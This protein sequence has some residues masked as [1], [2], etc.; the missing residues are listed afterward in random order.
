M[1]AVR[2]ALATCSAHAQGWRSDLELARLAG[3]EFVV[4]DRPGVDWSRFDTVVI[5]STWDY[6]HQLPQFLEW[7]ESVGDSRLLNSPATVRFAA[8]K[9]YLAG[10]RVPT[11]PTTFLEPGRRLPAYSGEVVIKPNIS[12]GARDTGRFTESMAAEAAALVDSIHAT[13]RSV[14]LQPYLSAVDAVGETAVV[15]FAGE[16]SHVLRK[17]PVLRDPGVAPLSKLAH[18]PAAVMLERDLVSA[19]EATPAELELALRVEAELRERLGE[20]LYARVDMVPGPD[21]QPVVME[22]ELI[23]PNLYF[24][25]APGAAQRFAQAITGARAAVRGD[26]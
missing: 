8:D 2:I 7:C 10:L 14:L 23:E 20:I 17:R 4:W 26:R 11:V 21:G 18:G 12:A 16:V 22:L 5:R 9:R 6:S 25:L 24:D 15:L 3:A 19:A 1:G 13:G